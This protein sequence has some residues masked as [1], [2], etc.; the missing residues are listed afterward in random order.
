M[1][2]L[3]SFG[4]GWPREDAVARSTARLRTRLAT[5]LVWCCSCLS[6]GCKGSPEVTANLSHFVIL[7]LNDVF[8]SLGS[9]QSLM[10]LTLEQM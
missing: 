8:V 9:S 10:T 1:G 2:A 4:M 5:T 6:R 3:R 7:V